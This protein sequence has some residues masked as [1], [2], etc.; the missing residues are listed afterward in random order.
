MKYS[1]RLSTILP[2]VTFVC[3]YPNCEADTYCTSLEKLSTLD[4]CID[5]SVF[6]EEADQCLARL[7][8]EIAKQHVKLARAMG[9]N[10]RN[11][12]SSQKSKV[13]NEEKDL[14]ATENSLRDLLSK[15]QKAHE[16]LNAYVDALIYTGHPAL[17]FLKEN[18]LLSERQAD[19]C[20]KD[21]FDQLKKRISRL[22]TIAADLK[23]A[24]TQTIAL[25]KSS[26]LIQNNL[27]GYER[28]PSSIALK[29][30]MEVQI[31]GV[32]NRRASDISGT[33]EIRK[34]R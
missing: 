14:A 2:F 7:N 16:E 8:S 4:Y 28:S 13:D 34:S 29:Q 20:W 9:K 32:S 21:N 15:T 24:N 6:V 10:D 30:R 3:A 23:Q 12:R 26:G 17:T 22:E 33:S 18:D 11:S 31:S 19:P 27:N 5:N 1:L 25:K